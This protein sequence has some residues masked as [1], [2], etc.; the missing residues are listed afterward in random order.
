M[1]ELISVRFDVSHG[2]MF[3]KQEIVCA[4]LAGRVLL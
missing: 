1:H 3:D 2:S 4:G